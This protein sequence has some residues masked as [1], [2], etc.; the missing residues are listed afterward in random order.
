V[1]ERASQVAL[2]IAGQLAAGSDRELHDCRVGWKMAAEQVLRMICVREHA[3]KFVPLCVAGQVA[4]GSET[5]LHAWGGV[6]ND[7]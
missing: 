3:H 2:C 1:R 7:S 5:I 6:E 4:A